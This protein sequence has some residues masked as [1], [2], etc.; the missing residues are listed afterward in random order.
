M[1]N[2][3]DFTREYNGSGNSVAFPSCVSIAFTNPEMS[4]RIR[5]ADY[6]AHLIGQCIG[7]LV[8]NKLTPDA[9]SQAI[10][11]SDAELACISALLDSDSHEVRLCLSQPGTIQLVNLSSLAFVDVMLLHLGTHGLPP[12]RHDVLKQTLSIL[13]QALPSWGSAELP[14]DRTHH[15]VG[16]SDDKFKRTCVSHFHRLLKLCTPDASSL[17]EDVRISCLRLCLKTLWHCA[18][19]YDRILDPM[20]IYFPLVLA[21]PEIINHFRTEHDPVAR[22][23]ACYFRA[24]VVTKLVDS[25]E[26]PISIGGDDNNTELACISAILGPQHHGVLL[27][28]YQLR[29]INL[30][31]VV[32][33]M[34]SE[35]AMFAA[36]GRPEY[37]LN[38]AADTL[39]IL[40]NGL[41]LHFIHSDMTVD[42]MRL[43]NG[44][45]SDVLKA[46]FPDQ[47]KKGPVNTLERLRQILEKP[48]LRVQYDEMG[49][50]YW[51]IWNAGGS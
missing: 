14:L 18:E 41:G 35:I 40:A 48:L 28:P 7:A 12:D 51:A 23:M 30:R 37:V 47:L 2:L 24:L 46:L 13:F 16:L 43:Q 21:S 3:W 32:S 33:L 10:P 45:H 26:S 22:I 4:H 39:S 8:V 49:A 17:L 50:G 15:P 38:M 5:Q 31:N 6:V 27:L 19:A 20:P 11:V 29:I 42:H 34:S 44:I 1:N 25:L 9:M 36:A